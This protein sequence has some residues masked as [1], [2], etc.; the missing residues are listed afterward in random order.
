MGGWKLNDRN[1]LLQGEAFKEGNQ[2]YPNP[3]RNTEVELNGPFRGLINYNST[4]GLYTWLIAP[5]KEIE[6]LKYQRTERFHLVVLSEDDRKLEFTEIS[7]D[8]RFLITS[9]S[10]IL[11]WSVNNHSNE[12]ILLLDSAGDTRVQQY[13]IVELI[14]NKKTR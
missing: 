14:N 5:D 11:D 13:Q 7:G 10:E 3:K 12:I 1:I 8:N 6:T 2:F 9:K 4:S